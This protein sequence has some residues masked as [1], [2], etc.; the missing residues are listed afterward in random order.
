MASISTPTDGY[1]RIFAH[2][3]KRRT[4]IHLGNITT[5]EAERIHRHVEHLE[6]VVAS[7]GV[8]DSETAL[9]LSKV[10][11][12]LHNKLVKA[13]LTVARVSDKPKIPALKAFLDSYIEGRTDAAH[14]TMCNLRHSGDRLVDC[15]GADKRIDAITKADAKRFAVWLID[16]EYAEATIART[17]KRAR[18][19][20]GHAIDDNLL[21]I[22]PF[23]AVKPGSMS[24]PDRLFFIDRETIANVLEACPSNE[25]RLIV[26]LCRFCGLRCPS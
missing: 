4:T 22:N 19:F 10:E 17:I 2:V 9:W 16:Q 8:V 1:K 14:S 24:N 18:Q 26:S 25:W 7:A 15:F 3:G 5:R 13:G 11:G 20:F 6:S 21:T 12:K 23:T